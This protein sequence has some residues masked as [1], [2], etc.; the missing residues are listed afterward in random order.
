MVATVMAAAVAALMWE[1]T[2]GLRMQFGGSAVADGSG[3]PGGGR[4]VSVR[5]E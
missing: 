4:R 2:L 3:L 1:E 5:G